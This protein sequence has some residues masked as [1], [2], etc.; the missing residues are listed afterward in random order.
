MGW[1]SSH[2]QPPSLFPHP[3]FPKTAHSAVVVALF[4]GVVSLQKE[5]RNPTCRPPDTSSH[6]ISGLLSSPATLAYAPLDCQAPPCSKACS[7]LSDPL[8]TSEQILHLTFIPVTLEQTKYLPSPEFLERLLP[9]E[10]VDPGTLTPQSIFFPFS[11]MFL[12]SLICRTKNASLGSAQK[13]KLAFQLPM[14]HQT[15]SF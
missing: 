11:K 15:S 7:N 5:Y 1:L 3:F 13:R 4:P 14:F 2:P 8:R 6:L 9:E 12:F 10:T